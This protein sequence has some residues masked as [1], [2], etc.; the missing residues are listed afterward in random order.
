MTAG[1]QPKRR[2]RASWRATQGVNRP[3]FAGSRQLHAG[4]GLRLQPAPVLIRRLKVGADGATHYVECPS[5][6][7]ELQTVN[8][9]LQ[10][11]VD[12]LKAANNDMMNLLNSTEIATLLLDNTLCVRCYTERVTR[13]INH[14]PGDIGRPVTDLASDVLSPKLAGET[15]EVL[16]TLVAMKKLLVTGAG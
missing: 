11:K 12:D 5:A 3:N 2:Q 8:A 6:H 10:V 16:R 14:I 1:I 9:E 15:R 13:I 4:I 7:E